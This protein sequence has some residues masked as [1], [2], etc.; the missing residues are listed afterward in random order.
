MEQ[1]MVSATSFGPYAPTFYSSTTPPTCSMIDYWFL[2][3]GWLDILQ[4]A[5]MLRSVGD[6]LQPVRGVPPRDHIPVLLQL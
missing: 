5:H 4:R 2:P 1:R 3:R 6:I